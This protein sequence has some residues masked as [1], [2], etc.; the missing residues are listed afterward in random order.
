ML[1]DEF[2]ESIGFFPDDVQS[3]LKILWHNF[4]TI[5]D[6]DNLKPN[7]ADIFSQITTDNLWIQVKTTGCR[8]YIA[9]NNSI[10]NWEIVKK[11]ETKT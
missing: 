4:N 9:F 11:K 10:S 8:Y 1:I 3:K 6:D 2:K 5:F 7:W